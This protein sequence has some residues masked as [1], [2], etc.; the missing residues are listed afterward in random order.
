MPHSKSKNKSWQ[1]NQLERKVKAAQKQNFEFAEDTKHVMQ[2]ESALTPLQEKRLAYS[3]A[4]KTAM[5]AK[6]KANQC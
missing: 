2:I 4:K 1:S 3:E 5:L 6:R